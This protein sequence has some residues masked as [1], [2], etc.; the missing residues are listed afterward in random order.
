MKN[1]T[2]IFTATIACL[3]LAAAESQATVVLPAPFSS[4]MVVQQHKPVL[5]WGKADAGETVT[6]TFC[7]KS[8]TTRA[9]EAG[10]FRIELPALDA[11]SNPGPHELSVIGSNTIVLKDVLLGEVWLCG[12][13]SNMR[14]TVKEAAHG[15]K[16]SSEANYPQIRLLYVPGLSSAKP[17]FTFAGKWAPCKPGTVAG[18]SAA[19]YYFGRELHQ[20]LG[21]PVGLID[22][23]QGWSP[24]EAWLPLSVLSSDPITKPIVD[25]QL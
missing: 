7:E 15:D 25:R 4:S 17:E 16:E 24:A 22:C 2:A 19:A 21:V 12:G 3:L 11:K 9:T 23:S 18:F 6:A 5:I 13:Q 1:Y 14:L 20:T 8:A 10:T